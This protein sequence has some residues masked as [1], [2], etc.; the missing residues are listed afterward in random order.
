MLTKHQKQAVIFS[1]LILITGL[2][3]MDFINPSL[4]YIMQS[5]STTEAGTKPLI[6]L[7]M[8]GLSLSQFFYGT[9]SDNHGR[10]KTILLSYFISFIGIII[11]S[12]STS[13]GMLYLGRLINGAGNGGASVISR[14]IIA[15]VCT[16]H[17]SINKA[18]SYF[19]TFG[20]IS[21]T[22]APILGGL[23]Q[24]YSNNWRWC[25]IALLFVTLISSIIIKMFMPETHTI[26][27]AKNSFLEQGKLYFNLLKLRTFMFYNLISAAIYVFSIAYYA[28]MP[29]ILFKLYFSPLEN[30][31]LYAVYA[32]FLIGGS[33][34]FGKYLN[35][36]DSKKIF[37]NCCIAFLLSAIIFYFYFYLTNSMV[38][39]I[40]LSIIISF[41][42]GISAPLTLSLCMHG[43]SSNKKGAA[44]AVQ[45]FIKMF[46]TGIT[47]FLFNFIPLHSM[48]ALLLC[49]FILAVTITCLFLFDKMT[50]K[51]AQQGMPQT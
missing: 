47:L 5:L 16:E 30:G 12:T 14:A 32:V 45:S 39:I 31:I 11:S 24:Q 50:I 23:I 8:I 35:K 28:Y 15:D 26:P 25:F 37:S 7:Y 33:L 17:R 18:F 41:I 51:L 48:T 36:F 2:M 3:A 46:F 4:P 42:C 6:A 1:C 38:A 10:K 43:F 29:F 44:S 9:F 27:S 19:T 40:L 21:P 20:M 49:Y 13:I 34:S 22:F